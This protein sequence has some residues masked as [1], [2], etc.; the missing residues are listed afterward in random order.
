[1]YAEPRRARHRRGKPQFAMTLGRLALERLL[2]GH[3]YD[4]TSLDILG[5]VSALR[6]RR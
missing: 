1:M 5:C 6:R 4:V 2:Q 3:G